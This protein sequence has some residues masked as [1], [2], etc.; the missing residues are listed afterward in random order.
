MTETIKAVPELF[1]EIDLGV[2]NLD[3]SIDEGLEQ[4]LRAEPVWGR[5]AARGFNGRVWFEDGLFHEQV[6]IYGTPVAY[7]SAP[8]LVELAE[9]VSDHHGWE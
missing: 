6:W 4:R 9:T 1:E 8:T 3:R 2:T 7:Y 5:H